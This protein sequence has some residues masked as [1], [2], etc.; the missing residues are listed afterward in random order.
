[1][2]A[3]KEKNDYAEFSRARFGFEQAL[4]LWDGNEPARLGLAETI[5]SHATSAYTKEDFDLGLSLLDVDDDSHQLLI[6][7][8]HEGRRV[9]AQRATRL[10]LFK[11]L[12]A[13]M[14]VFILVGGSIAIYEINK[15]RAFAEAETKRAN[16]ETIRANQEM[17][18][19]KMEKRAA[20]RKREE[21]NAARLAAEEAKEETAE[22]LTAEKAALKKMEDALAAETTA[23]REALESQQ[24]ELKAKQAAQVAA[25]LEKKQRET[26][27]AERERAEY[28]TYF[29]KIG[30]A[31]ARLDNNEFDDARRILDEVRSL[32][33]N[34]RGGLAWEWRWLWRQANQS[35]ASKPSESALTDLAVSVVPDNK[36]SFGV[37]VL[38]NG[39]LRTFFVD[40]Q[41]AIKQE[42]TFSLRDGTM[43]SSVAFGDAGNVVAV[44]T[45]R[46]DIQ[47]WDRDLQNHQRT[48]VGHESR[49]NCIQFVEDDLLVSGSSDQTARLW[50]VNRVE[51]LTTSWHIAD[52]R[53]LA[54]RRIGNDITVVTA[55]SGSSTG[56]A[57]AWSI[58]PGSD[59]AKRL[60]EFSEQSVPITAIALSPDG[61]E[62]ATG[63]TDGN[64]LFWQTDQ[65][66][67]TNYKESVAAAVKSLSSPKD[68]Q[69]A[70]EQP[71]ESETSV[72]F[73]RAFDRSIASG[74]EP[75]SDTLRDPE[76][77]SLTTS[78]DPKIAHQDVIESIQFSRDGATILTAS[79][80]YTIKVWD[81][82]D[83][84]L[85]KTLLGH[86]G[87][88]TDAVFAGSSFNEVISTSNDACIRRWDIKT[89]VGESSQFT[90]HEKQAHF[91]EIWSARFNRD[92]KQI[93]SA[94]RDHSARVLELKPD[95]MTFSEI[96]TMHDE[97]DER[98]SEGTPFLAMSFEFDRDHGRLFV[99]S[100]DAT[101]RIWDINK[102]NEIGQAIKTGLNRSF[103]LSRD[104]KHLLT[105]SSSTKEKAILWQM[106]PTALESPQ[107][108]HRLFEH[109]QA[110][111]AMAISPDGSTMFTGD[112]SGI[113]F[114][115]DTDTG[116]RIGKSIE[117][118]RGYRINAACFTSDSKHI[119]IASDDLHVTRI[120]VASRKFIDQWQHR[121]FVTQLS[122]SAD[123]ERAVT[124]SEKTAPTRTET[125]AR[126]W[127]LKTGNST[128][129]Y[130]AAL[131]TQHSADI[132]N[133][134]KILDAQF[135]DQSR[136]V[137]ISV[138]DSDQKSSRIIRWDSK[139]NGGT[140]RKPLT[141]EVPDRIHSLQAAMPIENDR[142]ITLNGDAAFLWDLR[143]RSH[144]KSYRDHGAV[145]QAAFSHDGQF[146][147]T[148]SRSV[149][150]WDAVTG[151]SLAKL[152]SP[153]DGLV[154]SIDFS[155]NKLELATAGDDGIVR[156]WLWE[157]ETQQFQKI[158]SL[159]AAGLD[160]KMRKPIRC[161]RYSTDGKRLLAVGDGGS[162]RLWSLS[163][164]GKGSSIDFGAPEAGDFTCAAFSPNDGE[165]IVVGGDDKIA[166][167]YRVVNGDSGAEQAAAEPIEFVGHADRIEDVA[168]IQDASGQM[169]VLTASRDKS[170]R[171]WDPRI[172]RADGIGREI[173]SL[174]R[175]TLGVTAIDA[176]SGGQIVMTAGRD[177]SVILWPADPAK[178]PQTENTMIFDDLNDSDVT[179]VK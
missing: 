41:G 102:G 28:E 140:G 114:L 16:Q 112:R 174:R 32:R 148:A 110:V 86:G 23:K 129:L 73:R 168:I 66:R 122:L 169:R 76:N 50:D 33:N 96:A 91:D 29:S 93:V 179:P 40:G 150:V 116:K 6:E 132:E 130:N 115:W 145:T 142:M 158:D 176:S 5:T 25:D 36:G 3:A 10:R 126:I 85:Q 52:V 135:G 31:K 136:W 173:V 77:D 1:M 54:A 137:I 69:P 141:L 55:V 42:H 147:A 49:V 2:A 138:V 53:D 109:D 100:A 118:V 26:A 51:P 101:I 34:Q 117:D 143:S 44:G 153:H 113:G 17:D 170:A 35:T 27:V 123:G 80:D 177:G 152:E 146:V 46:G 30:L 71:R 111:T 103:A 178:P 60:G 64:L 92:G 12:A 163:G 154:R 9:R 14:L 87:W 155:P 105:G 162:A 89:Y 47:I 21:A 94:S 156:Q 165:W 58:S 63:D 107:I 144:I 83:L 81:A 99:G 171:V 70:D 160:E 68:D 56:R 75:S 108:R 124:V 133:S 121:G 128:V 104:G 119:L 57:V 131:D 7:K 139:A 90:S 19:A 59:R 74:D 48:L 120:D 166:R 88:V 15:R 65:L 125:E 11:Q 18:N 62:V 172:E 82:K 38:A 8:L 20:D 157:P 39:D 159:D 127:N 151:Q 106:N 4:S 61:K 97:P 149:K 84:S 78:T 95:S 24:K 167:M 13:A 43:A 98:L 161:V 22:A 79:D 45:T 72:S 67:A 37:T 134:G 164:P 175:H